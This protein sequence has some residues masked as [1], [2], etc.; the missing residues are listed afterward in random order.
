M[1]T[2]DIQVYEEYYR[3]STINQRAIV[4]DAED[5]VNDSHNVAEKFCAII[6][7]DSKHVQYSWAKATDECESSRAKMFSTLRNSMGLYEGTK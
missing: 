6:G 7:L 5:M 4:I 3:V 1:A 2:T